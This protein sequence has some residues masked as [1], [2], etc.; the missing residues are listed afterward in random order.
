[1]TYHVDFKPSKDNKHC[2]ECNTELIIRKDDHPDTVLDRLKT[3][4]ETTEPL[5]AFYDARNK[6]VLVE[7]REELAETTK[8]TFEAIEA[9]LK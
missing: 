6:L 3:Y 8:A 5:K 1:M 9:Y 2:N 4:H 7:G